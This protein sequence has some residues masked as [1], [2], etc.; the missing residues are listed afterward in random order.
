MVSPIGPMMIRRRPRGH[1]CE[2]ATAATTTSPASPLP[3][4]TRSTY[5]PSIRIAVRTRHHRSCRGPAA[6]STRPRFEADDWPAL[7]CRRR[8]ES[9]EDVGCRR[10]LGFRF[11]STSGMPAVRR[12]AHPAHGAHSPSVEDPDV[13]TPCRRAAPHACAPASTS[14][15]ELLARGLRWIVPLLRTGSDTARRRRTLRLLTTAIREVN[16]YADV[17]VIPVELTGLNV[18]CYLPGW[19]SRVP[20]Q[21]RL[22]RSW[23]EARL[24]EPSRRDGYPSSIATPSRHALTT[25][26]TRWYTCARADSRSTPDM[27][28]VS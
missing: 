11:R 19:L 3:P 5:T 1:W 26:S 27:S 6:R 24:T 2:P 15:P 20:C 25:S 23:A 28:S 7:L 8:H 4:K 14:Q 12:Q 16:E 9:M 13:R 10:F 17:T 22:P 18:P 21:R